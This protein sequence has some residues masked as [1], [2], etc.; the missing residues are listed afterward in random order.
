[1]SRNATVSNLDLTTGLAFTIANTIELLGGP[2]AARLREC[3]ACGRFFLASRQRQAWCS[4]A[5]GNRTRVARHRSRRAPQ[6][7]RR[8]G[9]GATDILAECPTLSPGIQSQS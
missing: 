9:S 5:C 3:P 6:P 8:S 4:G 7:S 1:M 2:D